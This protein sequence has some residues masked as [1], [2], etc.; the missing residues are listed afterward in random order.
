MSLSPFVD[1]SILSGKVDVT[2]SDSDIERNITF[3]AAPKMQGARVLGGQLCVPTGIGTTAAILFVH[4]TDGVIETKIPL[5]GELYPFNE[6]EPEA[7]AL[8]KNCLITM[9][10]DKAEYRIIKFAIG[11]TLE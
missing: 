10:K 3:Q 8:Y 7:V 6:S 1:D 11:S 5:A 9:G 4:L 2:I